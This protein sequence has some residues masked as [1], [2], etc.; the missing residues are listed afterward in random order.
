M[1]NE[2]FKAQMKGM[3]AAP[4]FKEYTEARAVALSAEIHKALREYLAADQA[5][6]EFRKSQKD[7]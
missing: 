5:S 1:G 7:A 6:N 4:G 3:R 2:E